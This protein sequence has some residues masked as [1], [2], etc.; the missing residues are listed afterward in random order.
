[1]QV[2]ERASLVPRSWWR[3]YVTEVAHLADAESDAYRATVSGS[4]ANRVVAVVLL[5]AALALSIINFYAKDWTWLPRLV[6][7]FGFDSQATDLTAAFTSGP[8]SQFNGLAVWT[9][10]QLFAYVALPL[11]A[12]RAMR[13]KASDFGLRWRGVGA[14]WPVYAFLLAVSVP[15]VVWV[16]SSEA[17]LAKYPFLD[18]APGESLWPYMVGWWVMYG[19]Q[20]VAL[21]FFFRGFLV[22]G[23]KWRMGYAAIFVMVVPYNMIH[24]GKPFLEAMG[25]ILGGVTL[26]T[27]SLKTRSVWWGAG[28]HIAIAATM[29]GMALFHKGVIG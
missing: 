16:S 12:I 13:M 14:H 3:R 29:D 24:F 20:F 21:E 23:L 15:V 26:G 4:Q 5:T 28:L 18:L 17:F 27:L 8:A 25:A 6:G 2:S 22:H 9:G 11:L 10:V 19:L 7:R 1:M